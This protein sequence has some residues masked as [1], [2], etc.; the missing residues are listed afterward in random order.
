MQAWLRFPQGGDMELKSNQPVVLGRGKYG[1]S[2]NRI[3]R[4]H[5]R[6]TFSE[7][8]SSILA[9]NLSSVNPVYIWKKGATEPQKLDARI[10]TPSQDVPVESSTVLRNKDRISLLIDAFFIEIVTKKPVLKPPGTPEIEEEITLEISELPHI[11]TKRQSTFATPERKRRELQPS[12]STFMFPKTSRIPPE[13]IMMIKKI[14]EG[15]CGEV[16]K[17]KYGVTIVAV[18]K[19]FRALLSDSAAKEFQD[20][21]TMLGNLRHSKVVQFWGFTDFPDGCQAIVTEFMAKGALSDIVYNLEIPLDINRI[22]SIA[23]HAAE[24]I[25]YL[26]S[27]NIVHRDIKTMNFLVSD[28]WTVKVADFGLSKHLKQANTNTFC[29]TMPWAAPEVLSG[30]LYSTKVDVYSFGIVLWELFSRKEPY[31]ELSASQIILQVVNKGYRPEIP[32]NCPPEWKKLIQSC[33]H[34]N[35]DNRPTMEEVFSMLKQITNAD[36]DLKREDSFPNL[37]PPEQMILTLVSNST[38]NLSDVILDH[39]I[40]TSE[41]STAEKYFGAYRNQPVCIKLFSQNNEYNESQFSS[42]VN[43]LE[44]FNSPFVVKMI[45]ACYSP[46][47]AILTEYVP[48]GSV[49]ELMQNRAI[50][51]T[52]ELVY[53]VSLEAAR[54]VNF[55][56]SFR[57]GILHRNLKPSNFLL[58][59]IQEG[60]VSRLCGIKICDLAMAR[61]DTADNAKTFQNVR[62][63]WVYAD[64]ECFNPSRKPFSAKSDVYSFGIILWELVSRLCEKEHT[65]PYSTFDTTSSTFVTEVRDNGTRPKIPKDCRPV[66]AKVIVS[67][68]D[69]NQENRP[70]FAELETSLSTILKEYYLS[71]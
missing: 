5:L 60:T 48:G 14:G 34:Q 11:G 2:D 52:W 27:K 31:S 55:L 63:D 68:W 18:K 1:I 17:A 26:H 64:P 66:F 36:T 35:P 58:D 57:N 53:N 46:K 67:C 44:Q 30:A 16:W 20:E 22:G 19:I 15:S 54:A 47:L 50:E 13:K 3:S 33:W 38:V 12:Q 61:A 39:R 65:A 29:G 8:T 41:N 43:L 45:G 56:H 9:Q 51:F 21:A 28:D 42:E 24:G 69:G 62:S 70:T 6:V 40:S 23:L 59:V 71:Q 4:E 25:A 37:P 7:T 49:L 10:P 32:A